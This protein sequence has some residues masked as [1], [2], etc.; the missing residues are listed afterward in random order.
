[1]HAK[2]HV[3]SRLSSYRKHPAVWDVLLYLVGSG[4]GPSTVAGK[5]YAVLIG[6][7]SGHVPRSQLRWITGRQATRTRILYALLQNLSVDRSL[8][9]LNHSNLAP[10]DH[11]SLTAF[12]P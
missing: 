9:L 7:S 6:I 2:D 3:L 1:M 11:G 12:A 5:L 10:S 8:P 4:Y